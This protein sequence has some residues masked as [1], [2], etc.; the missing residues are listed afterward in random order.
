M[1]NV[2]T[3]ANDIHYCKTT[4]RPFGAAKTLD[5]GAIPRLSQVTVVPQLTPW[6]NVWRANLDRDRN[7]KITKITQDNNIF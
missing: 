3:A 2:F 5:F 7:I 6:V 1:D 4:E